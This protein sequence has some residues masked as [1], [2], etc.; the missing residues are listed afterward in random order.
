[1][2]NH[3]GGWNSVA[4]K[5]KSFYLNAT[6]TQGLLCYVYEQSYL[7]NEMPLNIHSFSLILHQRMADSG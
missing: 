7:Q 2:G 6:G 3:I 4:K 5:R 1:M